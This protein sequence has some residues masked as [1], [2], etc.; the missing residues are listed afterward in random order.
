MTIETKATYQ[1]IKADKEKTKENWRI[2]L[3]A[4]QRAAFL[5]S[6]YKLPFLKKIRKNMP[7]IFNGSYDEGYAEGEGVVYNQC[8]TYGVNEQK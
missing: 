6:A 4:V 1:I 7:R 2:K 8:K 3:R 5:L